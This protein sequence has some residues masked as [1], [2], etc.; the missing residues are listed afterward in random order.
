MTRATATESFS[1][2]LISIVEDWNLKNSVL[3]FRARSSLQLKLKY[4]C[5][6]EV[7]VNDISSL[8]VE[9]LKD[10]GDGPHAPLLVNAVPHLT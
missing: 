4:D 8:H 1:S 10:V 2:Y 7:E 9:V 6:V 3:Y 5:P